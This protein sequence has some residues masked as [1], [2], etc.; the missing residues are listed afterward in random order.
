M[1]T[2]TNTMQLDL[3]A[4]VDFAVEWFDY[5]QDYEDDAFAITFDGKR[6]YV[7]RKRSHFNLE[8]AGEVLKLPR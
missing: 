4:L 3:D 1:G 8:V 7:E 5:S 2:E 6:V